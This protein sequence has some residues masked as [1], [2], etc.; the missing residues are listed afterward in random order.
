MDGQ[1]NVYIY[2]MFIFIKCLDFIIETIVLIFHDPSRSSLAICMLFFFEGVQPGVLLEDWENANSLV[3]KS[4]Q[5][6][7]AHFNRGCTKAVEIG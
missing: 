1:Y 4:T 7:F 2:T 5:L 3:R 6:I